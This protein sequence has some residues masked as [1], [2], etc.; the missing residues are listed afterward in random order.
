MADKPKRVNGTK[1]GCDVDGVVADFT[2][3]LIEAAELDRKREEFVHWKLERS[4]TSEEMVRVREVL[5]DPTFYLDLPLIDG[6][7]SKVKELKDRGYV[8]VWVTSPRWSCIG[9]DT[10]RREWIRRHFG[11]DPVMITKDKQHADVDVLIDDK[12]ANIQAFLSERP[13]KKAL[14]YDAPYNKEFEEVPRVTWSTIDWVLPAI[15]LR[16]GRRGRDDN[17]GVVSK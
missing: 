6:A 8:F 7:K 12:P 14:L 3:G 16:G 5:D 13:D 17:Q 9:W 4:L 15:G 10:A 1:I 11:D 2:G